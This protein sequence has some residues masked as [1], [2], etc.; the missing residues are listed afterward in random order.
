MQ[1]SS[2]SPWWNGKART[3]P[4]STELL[5]ISRSREGVIAREFE[6][7]ILRISPHAVCT[8]AK[9]AKRRGSVS[10]LAGGNRQSKTA[11]FCYGSQ[12][13][14]ESL[15]S[16]ALHMQSTPEYIQLIVQCGIVS[17]FSTYVDTDLGLC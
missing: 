8:K 1:S 9:V 11:K 12:S 13:R 7:R 2:G 5:N 3:K 14:C 10:T 16:A 4:A 17:T 6:C 15:H